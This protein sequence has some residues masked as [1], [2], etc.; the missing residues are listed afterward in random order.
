MRLSRPET[1]FSFPNR[2]CFTA[3]SGPQKRLSERGLDSCRTK[4]KLCRG[5]GGV[6][7]FGSQTVSDLS[8]LDI[9]ALE[10]SLIR[11]TYIQT[12]QKTALAITIRRRRNYRT[13]TTLKQFGP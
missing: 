13:G 6:D 3:M 8:W 11:L 1:F 4:F 5:R 12:S 2:V 7:S 10:N 9:G